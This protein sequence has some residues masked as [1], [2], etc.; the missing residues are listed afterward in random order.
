MDFSFVGYIFLRL[1]F[2]LGI[3]LIALRYIIHFLMPQAGIMFRAKKH[4]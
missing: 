2:E 4:D 1:I 3:P